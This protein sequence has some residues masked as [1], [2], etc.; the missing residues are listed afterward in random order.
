MTVALALLQRVPLWLWLALAAIFAI[1]VQTH[2][3]SAAQH[4]RDSYAE[5]LST[6]EA[7]VTSLKVTAQLQR[8]LAAE[9]AAIS[10][11][12][13]EKLR[14]EKQKTSTLTADLAANR[15]WLQVHG[16]CVRSGTTSGNNVSGS[17]ATTFEL[18]AEAR[19]NYIDLRSG[20]SQQYAQIIGLQE[21]I[22]SL[23]SRCVIGK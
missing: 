4:D 16:Q 2:R 13:Q 10:G 1:A 18:D 20:L 8:D 15:K 12:Y 17:D 11:Q 23:E 22:R 19:Q 5:Q 3:L 14:D 7:R 9:S 6:S 21:R